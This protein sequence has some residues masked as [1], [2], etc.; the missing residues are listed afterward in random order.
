MDAYI[1]QGG[2]LM[3]INPIQIYNNLG[4]EKSVELKSNENKK[5]NTEKISNECS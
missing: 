4:Y 2:N 1:S 5:Q 3:N